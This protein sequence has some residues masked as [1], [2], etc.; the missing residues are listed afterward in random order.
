LIHTGCDRF[1]FINKRQNDRFIFINKRQN[2][3]FAQER[4]IAKSQD[5]R[6][7]LHFSVRFQ[8]NETIVPV[9]QT[10]F[11]LFITEIHFYEKKY[12]AHFS[13]LHTF[14]LLKHNHTMKS[15]TVFFIL[16]T[17]LFALSSSTVDAESTRILVRNTM[18]KLLSRAARR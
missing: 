10:V 8:Q 13:D 2:V 12:I 14:L 6:N 9:N 16:A 17:L 5:E 7:V 18:K 11:Y 4:A 3:Y 1:I 15:F